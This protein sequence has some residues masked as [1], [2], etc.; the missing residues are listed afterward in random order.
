M[1]KFCGSLR[2]QAKRIIDFEKKKRVLL[3]RKELKSHED[4][5]VWYICRIWFLKILSEN[6]NYRKA[7]DHGHYTGQDRGA[8][9][10]QYLLLFCGFSLKREHFNLI[11]SLGCL[12]YCITSLDFIGRVY[13]FS[14]EICYS[15]SKNHHIEVDVQYPQKL[16]KLHNDLPF[17]SE[18]MEIE[19]VEKLITNFYD[20]NE[21]DIQTRNLK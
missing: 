19:K 20:K 11:D 12:P 9:Y 3:T 7:R 8:A 5:K 16:H 2:K 1:K 4:A 6:I 13:H 17:L 10:S 15:C 21:Y 18:R 14:L